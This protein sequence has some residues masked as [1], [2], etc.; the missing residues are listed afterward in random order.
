M[1]II[2]RARLTDLN[3][4]MDISTATGSGMSSMPTSL[5]SWESKL[6]KSEESFALE[7]THGNGEIY[8][9]VMEDTASGKLVGT[10]AIYAGVGLD[11]PFYS[12]RVSTLISISKELEKKNKLEVLHLVN[13]F[14]GS[15]EIGS[16]YLDPDY[17][18]D[19]NGRFLSRCRFLMLADFPERFDDTIIAEMRGWQDKEGHS[20]FWEQLGRK[21]FGL[22]FENA[23]FMSAVKGNQFIT[24]LMPRHPIYVDLLPDEAR[25]VI[26]IPHDASSPALRLLEK[27]GFRKSGY[28]DIFDGGPTVQCQMRNISTVQHSDRRIV[29][30]ILAN[31][32]LSDDPY[33]ISNTN[34]KNYR[35]VRAPLILAEDSTV[36]ITQETAETLQVEPGQTI[37]FAK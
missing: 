20:P 4:L 8:F 35:F 16:L 15:T 26:G 33:M 6:H 34:L 37:S 27:E 19:G 21:F 31:D 11:Q 24:D 29:S 28:V 22:G 23:D 12:Y 25:N 32:S 13:D 14:T 2:R 1:I 7:T 17:R 10:T 30:E 5:T 18:K 9:M 36:H 3:C